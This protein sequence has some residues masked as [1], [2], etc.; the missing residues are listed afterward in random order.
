VNTYEDLLATETANAA[1][2]AGQIAARELLLTEAHIAK[3]TGAYVSELL[4]VSPTDLD[5]IQV[6]V[7]ALHQMREL[8]DHLTQAVTDGLTA[9]MRLHEQSK[10]GE[11]NG[12]SAERGTSNLV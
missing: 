4:K 11:S 3:R 5:K 10:Q 9:A 8:H 6:I 7:I 12:S 1:V 2:R